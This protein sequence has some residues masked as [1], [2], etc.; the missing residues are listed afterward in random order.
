MDKNMKKLDCH[1]LKQGDRQ[2][3][4]ILNASINPAP[5]TPLNASPLLSRHLL[6]FTYVILNEQS[7]PSF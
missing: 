1:K 3:S 7:L 5:G 2:A 4:A 6:Y